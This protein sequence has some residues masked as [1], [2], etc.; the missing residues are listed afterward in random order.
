LKRRT[1]RRPKPLPLRNLISATS[2]ADGSSSRSAPNRHSEPQPA[3]VVSTEIAE[4]SLHRH[5]R[6]GQ[7]EE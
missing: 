1:R 4:N 3:S 6:D 2:S 7:T 5:D